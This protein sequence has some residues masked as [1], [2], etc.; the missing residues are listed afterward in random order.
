MEVF[1]ATGDPD[2]MYYH[3]AMRK[4]DTKDFLEAVQEELGSMLSNQICHVL[5]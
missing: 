4:P 3:Q 5:S 1:L 2:T